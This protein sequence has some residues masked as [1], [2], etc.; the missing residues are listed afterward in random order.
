[1]LSVCKDVHTLSR[2]PFS[3]YLHIYLLILTVHCIVPSCDIIIYSTVSEKSRLEGLRRCLLLCVI[4]VVS[5]YLAFGM[6]E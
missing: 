1:M 4:K 5:N 6:T 3:I 2:E